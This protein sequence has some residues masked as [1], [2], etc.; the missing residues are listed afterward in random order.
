MTWLLVVAAAHAGFQLTVTSLVYPALV[1]TPPDGWATVHDLHSRRIAPLVVLLYG[2]L[3]VT[4]AWA[5]VSEPWSTALVLALVLAVATVLVTGAL[6][7]P[8][9][10]R[11]GRVG[12]RP[13]LVRR[14]LR[15]DRL[16]A[17]LAVLTL[18]AAGAAAL[19]R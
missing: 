14:L 18:L 8:L 10:G 6:A 1:A 5:A 15:V 3:V 4:G 9:H 19:T 13:E 11:V 16:R 7:A 17:V 12:P 2:G